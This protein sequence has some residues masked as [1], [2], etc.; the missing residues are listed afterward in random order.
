MH[1]RQYKMNAANELGFS[2]SLDKML[3]KGRN[4]IPIYSRTFCH[5][6]V[7]SHYI[8]QI[9]EFSKRGIYAKL[10]LENDLQIY[11]NTILLTN[12]FRLNVKKFIKMT[13]YR[14][15]KTNLPIHKIKNFRLQYMYFKVT[16]YFLHMKNME[17]RL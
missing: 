17:I 5:N 12:L 7:F 2:L 16:I 3:I 8:S 13:Y 1:L 15:S 11:K 4:V 14:F 10:Q 9:Y 6:I